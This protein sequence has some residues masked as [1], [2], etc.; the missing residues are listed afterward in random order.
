MRA[1]WIDPLHSR[2]Q[3][4]IIGMRLDHRDSD[5][6][7]MNVL[8]VLF[9]FLTCRPLIALRWETSLLGNS[10]GVNGAVTSPARQSVS[11]GW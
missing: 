10:H 7:V 5:E 11:A 9:F 6:T 4:A 8:I 3:V 1:D 2:R